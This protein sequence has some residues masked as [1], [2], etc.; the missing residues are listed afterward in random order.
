[1]GEGECKHELCVKRLNFEFATETSDELRAAECTLGETLADL[2]MRFGINLG[3]Q[4]YS[5]LD[6]I[7]CRSTD[8]K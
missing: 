2:N 1:M 4:L 3:L 7:R 8:T 6:R 5:Q